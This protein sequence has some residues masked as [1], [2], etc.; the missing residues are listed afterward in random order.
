MLDINYINKRLKE[1]PSIMG[2]NI[3]STFNSNENFAHFYITY[4]KYK[5]EKLCN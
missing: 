1:K 5:K 3:R 2:N 4:Q